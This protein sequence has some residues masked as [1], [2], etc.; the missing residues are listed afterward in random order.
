MLMA[1]FFGVPAENKNIHFKMIYILN[2]VV[3][4]GLVL[5]RIDPIFL[6]TITSMMN[7][8]FFGVVGLVLAYWAGSGRL[9]YFR[10]GNSIPLWAL[11]AITIV[12]A[13][14]VGVFNLGGFVGLKF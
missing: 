8:T 2:S 9:G 13:G 1:E 3:A 5:A 4:A 6:K 12:V 14:Y 11:T 10:N 7:A